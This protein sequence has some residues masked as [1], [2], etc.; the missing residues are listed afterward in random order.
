MSPRPSE[1]GE[2]REGKDR[3][4][5]SGSGGDGA[6]RDGDRLD[7]KD[8]GSSEGELVSDTELAKQ[9]QELKNQQD[10]RPG[11]DIGDSGSNDRPVDPPSPVEKEDEELLQPSLEHFSEFDV[12][13]VPGMLETSY[14]RHV[15]HGQAR[16]TKPEDGAWSALEQALALAAIGSGDAAAAYKRLRRR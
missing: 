13:G 3:G 15:D 12:L 10:H 11:A 4:E 6:Q 9:E 1:G 14:A 16:H 8:G 2:G 7:D 5:T